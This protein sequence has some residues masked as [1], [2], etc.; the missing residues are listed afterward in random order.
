MVYV[1]FTSPKTIVDLVATA[2]RC[3]CYAG[4]HRKIALICAIGGQPLAAASAAE[5]A[6][7]QGKYWEM[8]DIIFQNQPNWES[9]RA[10]QRDAKFEALATQVGLNMDQFRS[11]IGSKKI[12]TKI[13]TDRSLGIKM[14]VN[15]TPTLFINGKMASDDMVS[16]AMS[17]NGDKLRDRLDQLI[18]ENGGTPPARTTTQ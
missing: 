5:A 18:K 1:P 3:I 13:N 14:G 12:G 11:D 7:L 6:G 10:D 15:S 17:G 2:D 4:C 8:H 9:T 16:D